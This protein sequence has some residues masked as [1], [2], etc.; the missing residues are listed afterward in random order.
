M[1]LNW[2]I[3]ELFVVNLLNF[4]MMNIGMCTIFELEHIRK[5][6]TKNDV[7]ICKSESDEI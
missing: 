3:N 2:A 6:F 4:N 1:R 7:Q 5:L